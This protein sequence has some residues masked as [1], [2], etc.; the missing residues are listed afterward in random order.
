MGHHAFACAKRARYAKHHSIREI[1]CINSRKAGAIAETE[2]IVADFC[3]A[4]GTNKLDKVP[5]ADIRVQEDIGHTPKWVDVVN[6]H[7]Y[8]WSSRKQ[9]YMP[10]TVGTAALMKQNS[11]IAKYYRCIGSFFLFAIDIFGRIGNEGHNLKQ[12]LAT[13]LKAMKLGDARTFKQSLYADI[14]CAVCKGNAAIWQ[15]CLPQPESQDPFHSSHW[16]I[17]AEA[18]SDARERSDFD[19]HEEQ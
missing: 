18:W 17:G 1:L 5:I 12:V 15:Q 11:N 8:G 10:T 14:A 19:G 16:D 3:A 13:S 4:T 6:V 2:Q 9:N 7:N